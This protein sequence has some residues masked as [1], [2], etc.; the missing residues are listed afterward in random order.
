M[1]KEEEYK[2]IYAPIAIKLFP[3]KEDQ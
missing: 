2:D 3:Q 1:E